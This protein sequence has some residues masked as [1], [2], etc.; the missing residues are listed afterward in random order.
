MA[1][2]ENRTATW[3][4]QVV[5]NDYVVHVHRE[6]RW[7]IAKIVRTVRNTDS[8]SLLF[9]FAKKIVGA[10]AKIFSLQIVVNYTGSADHD[11]NL[12]KPCLP[13][14]LLRTLFRTFLNASTLSVYLYASSHTIYFSFYN[15]STTNAF[16]AF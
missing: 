8:I 9:C 12:R 3:K 1:L 6:F 5:T 4:L 16:K 13:V 10:S 2:G 15:T 14:R 7:T 11:I